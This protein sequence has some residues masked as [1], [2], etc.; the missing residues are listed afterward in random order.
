MASW[1]KIFQIRNPYGPA[2]VALYPEAPSQTFKRGDFVKLNGSGQVEIAKASNSTYA[3]GLL[4]SATGVLGMVPNDATGV[5]GN[6]T[7]VVLADGNT[8]F[9]LPVA[10]ATTVSALTADSQVGA[11]YQLVHH[12]N[13]DAA[14]GV[15]IDNT[16]T[17]MVAVQEIDPTNA[18]GVQY[19]TVWTKVLPAASALES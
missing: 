18:V 6:V 15:A 8:E 7:T 1:K 4:T 13:G 2:K 19:G 16:S 9:L 5:T 3:T 17:P 11:V 14:W 12:V 10:H